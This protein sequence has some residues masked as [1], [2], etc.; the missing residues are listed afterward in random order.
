MNLIIGRCK[1]CVY[2][3]LRLDNT[4]DFTVICSMDAPIFFEPVETFCPICG[5]PVKKVIESKRKID[6]PCQNEY[7]AHTG[8]TLIKFK[9]PIAA[10]EESVE[11][12]MHAGKVQ[13]NPPGRLP[14]GS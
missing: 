1:F 8:R 9:N 3:F 7:F 5:E 13:D 4:D 10:W 14:E 2:F 6:T 12:K 11:Y